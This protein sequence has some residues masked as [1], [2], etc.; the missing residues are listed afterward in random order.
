MLYNC[1]TDSTSVLNALKTL[2]AV[3][4][5]GLLSLTEALIILATL[6][7]LLT[8]VMLIMFT[9]EPKFSCSCDDPG[10]SPVEKKDKLKNN[11]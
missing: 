6:S 11:F 4:V 3:S 9:G 8:F 5:S 7:L 1:T 10:C 2:A